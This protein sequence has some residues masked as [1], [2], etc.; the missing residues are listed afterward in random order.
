M[1]T[2][3]RMLRAFPIA[4]GVVALPIDAQIF[5]CVDGESTTYQ[6]MPCVS[7]QVE[8]RLAIS[9]PSRAAAENVSA[10]QSG[11][12]SVASSP[13]PPRRGTPWPWRRTLTLGMSDDEVLNLPG[14]GIPTRIIRARTLRQWREEWIYARTPAEERHLQFVNATLVD[15]ADRPPVEIVASLTSSSRQ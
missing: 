11:P 13:S 7:A 8:I 14:W 4:L 9:Q 15:I 10:L 2:I 12:G 3:S 1:A 5:K 6:S